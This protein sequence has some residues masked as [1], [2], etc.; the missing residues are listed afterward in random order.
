MS[1]IGAVAVA[2]IVTLAA[3]AS[4]ALA[5]V[6][7]VGDPAPALTV[8]KWAQGEPVEKI[9]E[10]KIYVVEF[11]ATWCGPCRA[12]IPHLNE[13]SKKHKDV[14]FI[15]ANVWEQDESLVEP[16]IKQ[17]GEKMT[18]RVALDDKSKSEKGAMA[19][20]W[21]EAAG[22]NGIPA[23]FIVGKDSKIA[24]IGHP[25]TMDEA[26]Q[27][28]VDGK[29][30]MKAAAEKA[31]KAAANEGKLK[32]I[33]QKINDAGRAQK[34][35]EMLSLLDEMA[36]IDE[37]A[38]EQ[39][40]TIK[41]RVLLLGAKQPEKAYAMADDLLKAYATNAQALN[42]IAFMVVD[43]K[44]VE[45]RDYAFAEKLALKANEIT[46]GKD[47]AILDTVAAV[48]FGK[49]D[50]AK[51]IEWQTKAVEA[52]PAGEMKDELTKTLEKYKAEK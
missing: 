34:W 35:D 47:A 18:Y 40:P 38:A 48:Y 25:A 2:A 46:K 26:L 32:A 39:V 33:R 37:D 14:V 30:D 17:M 28:I 5:D 23:A 31:A 3:G 21:M 24:W 43:D 49:G 44:R 45:T 16:F 10:G 13:L 41:F 19:T 12:T 11:W 36:T 42:G 6:L 1:R 29:Y 22:Q 15:G 9:E 27:Q 4:S 8:A 50:T 7:K 20:N 52:A 51:A